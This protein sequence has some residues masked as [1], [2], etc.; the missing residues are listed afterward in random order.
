MGSDKKIPLRVDGWAARKRD[1]IVMYWLAG[2]LVLSSA[3]M[4]VGAPA[5][6]D[7]EDPAE[8]A[9]IEYHGSALGFHLIK[10]FKT[11]GGWVCHFTRVSR[12]DGSTSFNVEG[13]ECEYEGDKSSS[14]VYS[15]DGFWPAPDPCEDRVCT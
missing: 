8:L 15:I 5:P 3:G 4:I 10:P 13:L 1:R 12:A 11:P 2:I 14:R 7:G 9:L 6:P